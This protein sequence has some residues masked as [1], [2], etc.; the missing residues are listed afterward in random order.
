VINAFP[1]VTRADSADAILG[2]W[3]AEGGDTRV[4]IYQ[5]GGLFFGKIVAMKYPTTRRERWKA[6]TASPSWTS[7]IRTRACAREPWWESKLCRVSLG[8]W[9]MGGRSNLRSG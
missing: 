4:E 3:I 1:I 6:W 8:R 2:G 9:Q 5:K 7:I